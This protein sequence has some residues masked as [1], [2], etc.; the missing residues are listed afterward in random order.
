MQGQ[1]DIKIS[2]SQTAEGEAPDIGQSREA[3][4]PTV[5][6]QAIAAVAISVGKQMLT[7]GVQQYASLTGNYVAAE[8][9]SNVVS[10]ISK[11]AIA[12]TGPVGIIA[13]TASTGLNLIN[14]A[15]KQTIAERDIALQQQRAGFISTQGSRYK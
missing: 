10:I 5:Q 15:V 6:N 9:F 7:Q 8:T 12:A 13:V 3:G 11:V 14:S 2:K 1:I 4:K